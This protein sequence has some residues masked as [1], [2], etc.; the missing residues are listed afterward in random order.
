MLYFET[1]TSCEV[2]LASIVAAGTGLNIVC[3]DTAVIMEPNWNP[4]IEYQALDR[5]HRIGQKNPV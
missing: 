1:E 3:A 4:A 2:L 5:L